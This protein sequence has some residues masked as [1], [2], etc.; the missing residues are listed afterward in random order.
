MNWA[1]YSRLRKGIYSFVMLLLLGITI[2]AEAQQPNKIY[3]IGYL[4]T[5]SVATSA[6]NHQ[7]FIDA[8]RQLSYI[9]GQN[10]R[11]ENRYADG[12]N[13][14]LPSLAADLVRLKVT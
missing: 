1:R 9:E 7:A 6:R 12:R 14:N 5:G 4:T 11:I 13:E 3:R 8:L 2:A 10:V